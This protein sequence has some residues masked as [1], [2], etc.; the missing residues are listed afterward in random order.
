MER[1]KKRKL[2]KLKVSEEVA[3]SLYRANA[4]LNEDELERRQNEAH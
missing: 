3:S 1:K 4:N 2:K